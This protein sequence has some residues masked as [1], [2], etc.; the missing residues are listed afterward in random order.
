MRI[1]SPAVLPPSLD[2]NKLDFFSRWYGEFTNVYE[3]GDDPIN[4]F[5]FGYWYPGSESEHSRA[6]C[7]IEEHE[8]FS[9]QT[10]SY[11]WRIAEIDIERQDDWLVFSRQQEDLSS[12]ALRSFLAD[13]KNLSEH[14]R[15]EGKR[16]NPGN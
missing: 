8:R 9:L 16:L 6:V 12:D 10:R 15:D 2:L 11:F 7:V 13:C 14:L 1:A 5:C 3:I 4:T